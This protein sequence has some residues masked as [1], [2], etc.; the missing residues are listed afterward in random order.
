MT[1]PFPIQRPQGYK[2]VGNWISI[3]STHFKY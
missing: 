2:D 1:T 3:V